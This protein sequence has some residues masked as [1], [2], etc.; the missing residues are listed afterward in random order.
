MKICR[1]RW[2]GHVLK[3]PPERIPKVGH[4]LKRAR[5]RPKTTWRQTVVAELEEMGLSWDRIQ[6]VAKDRLQWL[7][8]VAAL[9]PTWDKRT[10]Q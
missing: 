8:I 7:T 2:L 3:K 9:C 10:K 5:G 1:L 4:Q 6:T